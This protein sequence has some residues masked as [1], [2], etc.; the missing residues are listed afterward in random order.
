MQV[1]FRFSSDVNWSNSTVFSGDMQVPAAASLSGDRSYGFPS[2]FWGVLVSHLSSLKWALPVQNGVGG[3]SW[4]LTEIKFAG[5]GSMTMDG[6]SMLFNTLTEL[7]L[8][9]WRPALLLW[10]NAFIFILPYSS[11]STVLSFP[12]P[13]S[14]FCA[15]S[16][17]N[18]EWNDSARVK[19][20]NLWGWTAF[21]SP[22]ASFSYTLLISTGGL[23]DPPG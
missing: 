20:Y 19:G 11:C 2:S 5:Y 21:Y 8:A 13:V 23:A 4:F 15:H 9:W 17:F 1:W 22:C 18:S 16:R 3:T 14:R 10:T 12:W 6:I 7:N